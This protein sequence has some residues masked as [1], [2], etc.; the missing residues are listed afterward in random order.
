MGW[1]YKT[2]TDSIFQDRWG[3]VLVDLLTTE[4]ELYCKNHSGDNCNGDNQWLD[5]DDVVLNGSS[6]SKAP[7]FDEVVT[8]CR[9]DLNKNGILDLVVLSKIPCMRIDLIN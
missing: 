3:E 2:D 1:V 5:V 6:L 8:S 4:V 9:D 7:T